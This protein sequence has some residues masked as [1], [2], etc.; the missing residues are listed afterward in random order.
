MDSDNSNFKR[1]VGRPRLSDESKKLKKKLK[2]KASYES[3]KEKIR[4]F[5]EMKN[6]FVLNHEK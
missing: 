2:N 6:S 3:K 4:L 5:E 1:P